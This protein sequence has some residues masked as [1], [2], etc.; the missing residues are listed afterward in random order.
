MLQRHSALPLTAVCFSTHCITIKQCIFQHNRLNGSS[1]P[2]STAT[3][4]IGKPKIRL[5]TESKP[6]TRLR[7]NQPVVD[8]VGEWT[9][10]A[11]F[12]ANLSKEGFPANGWN[13]CKQNFIMRNAQFRLKID[14]KGKG[15]DRGKGLKK[16]KLLLTVV[17]K[18]RS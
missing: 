11:K 3:F 8:N 18:S 4:L 15:W 7:L 12:Y 5:P 6:L 16:G 14:Q 2:V 13:I 1:S 17:F 10:Q 9:R